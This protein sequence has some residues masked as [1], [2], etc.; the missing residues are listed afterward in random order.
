[1]IAF[2]AA[3]GRVA[4][5]GGAFVDPVNRLLTGLFALDYTV[6][7]PLYQLLS[8]GPV[9]EEK[10]TIR[11]FAVATSISLDRPVIVEEGKRSEFSVDPMPRPK[12]G[13]A[14]LPR[15]DGPANDGSPPY[16]HLEQSLSQ[17][18]NVHYTRPDKVFLLSLDS[19]GGSEASVSPTP[20]FETSEKL[21][22]GIDYS[23]VLDKL[24]GFIIRGQYLKYAIMA[25]EGEG[26]SSG[27]A[28]A[29]PSPS[30]ITVLIDEKSHI[31]KTVLL[32]PIDIREFNELC[33]Y[34]LQRI[35]KSDAGIRREMDRLSRSEE[36]ELER[37]EYNTYLRE[38]K[39]FVARI[40]KEC[41]IAVNR[42]MNMSKISFTFIR[43]IFSEI[44]RGQKGHRTPSS[45]P[46][47]SS[48]S[49][50]GRGLPLSPSN[51]PAKKKGSGG[52]AYAGD[53]GGSRNNTKRTKKY[54]RTP[55]KRNNT[56]RN[57]LKTKSSL[58]NTIKRRKTNRRNNSRRRNQ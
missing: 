20:S 50:Q 32:N 12:S 39:E 30:L 2:V 5:E 27:M 41:E 35:V 58:R 56:I 1:L 44:K 23:L 38:I 37:G 11:A 28:D 43:P 3:E 46:P 42:G 24:Y 17:S 57:K 18:G 16:S 29:E 26:R 54:K 15:A 21:E 10:I 14:S 34:L 47:P 48:S 51:P 36:D 31:E 52:A 19:D 22:L 4:A 45:S 13:S 53:W 9:S 8:L 25:S 40:Q 6:I 33:I 49:G 55:N 7:K